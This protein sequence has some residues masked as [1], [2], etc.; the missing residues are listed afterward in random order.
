[1]K[2]LLMLRDPFYKANPKLIEELRE[3]GE[4]K[5]LYTDNGIE[6]EELKSEVKDVNIILVAVVKIDKDVIDAAPNLQYILKYGAGYDNIDVDYAYQKGI[7]V[8][9]APGLNAQS[10]ADHAF[11]LMLS[12]AREIPKKVKEMKSQSWQL[13]MGYEIHNKKLGIIGFGSIG[14]ALAKR[15]TGFDMETIAFANHKD[16]EAA[17][18][19]NVTFVDSNQ[20]FKEADFIIIATS[21]TGLNKHLVNKTTLSLMKPTSFL[22]NISRG[23]LVN[24]EDLFYALKNNMIQGAALDVFEMEPTMSNLPQLE[25]VVATPHIGGATFESIS[26]IGNISVSNIKKLI[27]GEKLEYEVR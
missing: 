6:K 1:M 7:R 18:K 16:H 9:N 27:N 20:L 25:N 22:I 10:A 19:L 8:T 4:V 17:K 5:V 23:A 26:R 14:Q 3:L 2:I 15:A 24:E 13:S 11:G 12:A 21:L